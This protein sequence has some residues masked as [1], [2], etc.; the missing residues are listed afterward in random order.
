[1]S[2]AE[3]LQAAGMSAA[4][5]RTTA[6]LFDS[7]RSALPA[8]AGAGEAAFFVPG[9]IEVLGKHTDYAGG[10][11]LVCAVERGFVV[12]AAPR[13]DDRVRVIDVAGGRLVELGLDS[14]LPEPAASWARYPATVLRR[15]A[16]N[17]PNARRGAELSFLS[18]LP[19][20]S[21]MSSSSAFMVAV[22]KAIAAINRLDLEAIYRRE[23]RSAE[24]L[25][26]YLAT[27][28]NGQSF[29]ALTGDS[30][31]GTFGG[32]EDHTAML[33]GRPGELSQ[34]SFCP[35][36]HERQVPCPPGY[37]FAV[38]VSGVVAEKTGAARESYNRASLAVRALLDAWR[39]VSGRQDASLAAAVA[40][41]AAAQLPDV[42]RRAEA[43]GFSPAM[44]R[45]R[46]E[47]FVEESVTLI[48]AAGDALSAGDLA[49]FGVLVDRSQHLAEQLLGN[50]V[51]ETIDLAASARELGA[52]A[53][54][55]FGAGFGG[56]VWALVPDAARD[57][58]LERWRVA[59]IARHPVPAARATFLAT[60]PGPAVLDLGFLLRDPPARHAI[61]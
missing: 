40:G 43:S 47:Q 35:V 46:F 36:R 58:F 7:A 25:A 18:D 6:A 1:M 39:S 42:L 4:A 28:E 2:N 27:V 23:I 26:G 12:V 56:S 13:A 15:I 45:A 19:L 21:G 50:Q 38:A 30:G 14:R 52:A 57:A 31:V 34:Y 10:R 53:A 51:P 11:S 3:S 20:A 8:S 16:R 54:S 17:F 60:R 41:G 29:G 22:F 48:P 61:G 5:S 32:S 37:V 24:D 9:R 44:L 33:C 49:R 59:Y 55:A